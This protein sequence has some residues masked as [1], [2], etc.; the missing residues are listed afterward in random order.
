MALLVAI[1]LKDQVVAPINGAPVHGDHVVI[2]PVISGSGSG[3]GELA[4]IIITVFMLYYFL[5]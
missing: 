2:Q 3:S 1:A 5:Y 4:V